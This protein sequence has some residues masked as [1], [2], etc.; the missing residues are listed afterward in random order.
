MAEAAN[1]AKSDFLATMS[2]EIRTPMNGMLVHGRTARRRR[3]AAAPAAL[4][5]DHRPLR[6]RRLLAII[7]DILDLSKIEAGKLELEQGR[8]AVATIVDDVS[9][10]VL[11]ACRRQG[12]RPRRRISTRTCRPLVEGDPV[13]LS[14]ILSNLVNNALKFTETGLG[15]VAVIGR[16]G[17]AAR[18][19]LLVAVEDTGIGIPADKIADDLRGLQP[20]RPVDHASLRRHRPR[21]FDLPASRRRHG[22]AHLG[23]KH[24]RRRFALRVRGRTADPRSRTGIAQRAG[25]RGDRRCRRQGHACRHR[26][27]ARPRRV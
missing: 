4:C 6:A 14:Q 24:R 26:G 20:G 12:P 21:P 19:A 23:G 8:V 5:R 11:R 17:A 13:R 9:R 1:R 15:P 27:R 18:L 3:P 7:N 2:H 16:R 22:R 10:S 25:P